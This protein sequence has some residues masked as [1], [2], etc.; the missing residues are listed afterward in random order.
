MFANDDAVAEPVPGAIAFEK[1]YS[2][3]RE[4]TTLEKRYGGDNEGVG[5]RPQRSVSE[6]VAVQE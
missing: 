4:G 6:E 5:R 1:R 2:G 3:D